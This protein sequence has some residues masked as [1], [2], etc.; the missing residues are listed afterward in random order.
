[1]KKEE[2]FRWDAGS[3][4]QELSN[5][6]DTYYRQYDAALG[7]FNAIDPMASKYSSVTPYNYAFSDPVSLNDRYLK[8]KAAK[9]K[10]GSN[11][12]KVWFS[13]VE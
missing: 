9:L 2:K 8:H 4:L 11:Q 7:R 3:E 10:C 6:Y 5:L 12:K 1:M 13:R